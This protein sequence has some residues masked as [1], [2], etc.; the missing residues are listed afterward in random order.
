MSPATTAV[1][2]TTTWPAHHRSV[3]TRA[4]SPRRW[5]LSGCHRSPGASPL[6]RADA[7]GRLLPRIAPRWEA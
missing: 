1:T 5:R 6:H 4:E 3:P 2:A 7:V